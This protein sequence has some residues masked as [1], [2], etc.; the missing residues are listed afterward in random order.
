MKTN[1]KF[2]KS[3]KTLLFL[4]GFVI[5][6]SQQ[7]FAQSDV[8]VNGSFES[9]ST[10]WN[11]YSGTALTQ[12]A[13]NVRSGTQ[14][15]QIPN[16]ASAEQTITGLQPNTTYRIQAWVKS[17][18]KSEVRVGAKSYG[19]SD[20]YA[21]V[22]KD[23]YGE[24]YVL[25]TTGSSNTSAIV[26]F[27][28]PSSGGTGYGDDIRV[29]EETG[30]SE[31]TL[32]WAEEFN[33]EGAVDTA[34]WK[35]E[36]GFVRN[37]EL[38]W[39]QP[40]NAFVTGGNLVF[41]GRR[42]TGP[43]PNYDP[44]STNWK[45]SREF[46][47]YT[48]AS[49]NTFGKHEWL[50]GRIEVRAKVTNAQGTWP[51][52]WT[53]GRGCEWPSN[54]EVDI[55]ENYGNKILA[56]YAWGSNTRWS[57]VWDGASR[58]VSVF[59]AAWNTRYHVWVLEWTEEYM[60]IFLDGMLM[61]ELDLSNIA[62]GTAA[63]P[64]ENPFRK[65]QVML[66]N[67]ALGSNG[68]DPTPT[69]FPQQYLV[70]YVRVY[71]RPDTSSSTNIALNKPAITDS[72][73]NSS[74]PASNAVDGNVSDNT[75]RW[76]S[77]ATTYP[78]WIEIDLQG[79]YTIDQMK[80]W[81]GYNG[82]NQPPSDF[83]F[84]KWNGST[85]V[86]IFTETG[87]TLPQYARYF[88]PTDASKVRLYATNGAD[89]Y[90]RLYEIEVYGV[91]S[92]GN[93]PP[94]PTYLD[95]NS[96][97]T[98]SYD[99]QDASANVQVQDGGA[100]LL[101]SNNTWR[102]TDQTFNVTAN[103]MLEFEFRSDSQGEIHGIGLDEDNSLSSNRIF[104]L[105]GTQNWGMSGHDYTTPG[106]FQQFTIPVGGSYTGNAMHLVF[107]NDQ[108]NGSGSNS[109]FKNVR[110]YESNNSAR[111]ATNQPSIG[112]E[113]IEEQSWEVYPNPSEVNNRLRYHLESNADV[114]IRISSSS[115]EQL[116]SYTSKNQESGWHELDLGSKGLFQS[117][118]KPGIYFIE[119]IT[120][121]YKTVKRI[122]KY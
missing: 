95:F 80:F 34:D 55:M 85:W 78:H 74:Y 50:Y 118:L 11:L 25:F 15:V 70:D 96:L 76:V 43:N 60:K 119:I 7:S 105:Y 3:Q 113:I 27:Y 37:Q 75:S 20:V 111:V 106:S 47:N 17:T 65:P 41:E 59:D 9:G 117:S 66:L 91:P 19:G 56:N 79:T 5:C 87:N 36:N 16:G 63:C 103:T 97:T 98:S 45:K 12:T 115:G 51:A 52:I 49:I 58:G 1:L 86:D 84:Q 62:N 23:T 81:T 6:L 120:E 57:A 21:R 69:T 29:L 100:T 112:H 68:G 8:A 101:L 93:P 26:Y 99:N 35:F 104:N 61:N 14:A 30:N 4:L 94:G 114:E 102:K 109:Y 53:L 88:T 92:S 107:A 48:S 31:Y 28:K 18:D 67:L 42:E 71:Q 108:D 54:G 2:Y 116:T 82:Y 110:L 10:N 72:Q 90:L 24:A 22:Y 40:D 73:L 89:N 121:D 83:K 77:D 13:A 33:Y 64:G 44:N 32:S 46:Y 39:Y 38:Q 122:V